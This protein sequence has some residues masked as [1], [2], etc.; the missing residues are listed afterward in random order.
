MNYFAN[1]PDDTMK[2]IAIAQARKFALEAE[3]ANLDK[4]GIRAYFFPRQLGGKLYSF[5]D[6]MG[7]MEKEIWE[8]WLEYARIKFSEIALE[9]LDDAIATAYDKRLGLEAAVAKLS[10]TYPDVPVRFGEKL[11]EVNLG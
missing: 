1:I 3:M 10:K 9:M 11:E 5:K 8:K 2:A 7:N 6:N 4:K